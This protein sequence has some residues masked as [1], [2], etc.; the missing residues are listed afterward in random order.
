MVA[1]GDGASAWTRYTAPMA[2]VPLSFDP[3]PGASHCGN[4]FDVNMTVTGELPG[5]SGFGSDRK[6]FLRRVGLIP[7]GSW[8]ST[9]S[10]KE[11]AFVASIRNRMQEVEQEL[12]ANAGALDEDEEGAIIYLI[13]LALGNLEHVED[14]YAY[15]DGVGPHPDTGIGLPFDENSGQVSAWPLT[16]T[17]KI[18]LHVEECE[19]KTAVWVSDRE[20]VGQAVQHVRYFYCPSSATIAQRSK[21]RTRIRKLILNAARAIR[22]AQWGLW[23]MLLYKQ[24]LAAW[25]AQYGGLPDLQTPT[26]PGPTP[27]GAVFPGTFQSPHRDE[28]IPPIPERPDDDPP[29]W[30]APPPGELPPGGEDDEAVPGDGGTGPGPDASPGAPGAPGAG[31]GAGEGAA[32]EQSTLRRYLPLGIAA[33]G[34]ALYFTTAK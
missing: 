16:A 32:A 3:E 13:K 12:L 7:A 33:A 24:S 31:A 8:W 23:R 29:D 9:K 27:S 20:L 4:T 17:D 25:D 30:K 5:K 21:D 34:L 18:Y 14:L 11:Q 2:A 28:P 10:A 15:W 1:R 22:C 19:G 6:H 26:Q